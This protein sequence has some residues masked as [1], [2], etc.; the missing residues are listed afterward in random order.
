M[1]H[2][3]SDQALNSENLSICTAQI[4]SS[5]IDSQQS[6]DSVKHCH[7]ND[8]KTSQ[9]KNEK[10]Q[11]ET[12]VPNINVGDIK[13]G[14]SVQN[15]SLFSKQIET[16]EHGNHI[17]QDSDNH[18]S[19]PSK[20][21]DSTP[22]KDS[23]TCE[24]DQDSQATGRPSEFLDKTA[25][26]SVFDTTPGS[27]NSGITKPS[28]PNID[29]NEDNNSDIKMISETCLSPEK[30]SGTSEDACVGPGSPSIEERLEQSLNL[31]DRVKKRLN[32]A[33]DTEKEKEG[34]DDNES[35]IYSTNSK[36]N[37]VEAKSK[38][39]ET[40]EDDFQVG[41]TFAF[42]KEEQNVESKGTNKE[43]VRS[44][45]TL[46]LLTSSDN[47]AVRE[48]ESDNSNGVGKE[49]R[50]PSSQF[51]L[52]DGYLPGVALID[53]D[54][55]V[56]SSHEPLPGAPNIPMRSTPNFSI[57][58]LLG[59]SNDETM[60]IRNTGNVLIDGNVTGTSS[61]EPLPGAPSIPMQSTPNLS[62]PELPEGSNDGKIATEKVAEAAVTDDNVTRA[63]VEISPGRVADSDLNIWIRIIRNP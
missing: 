4:E 11:G 52:T 61:H 14:I 53:G 26:Q 21:L 33:I 25:N 18:G 7:D 24:D 41:N 48:N 49:E 30:D 42:K 19:L 1:V 57:P 58:E 37:A 15:S 51:T 32:A 35:T 39:N 27:Q 36:E 62:I 10:S 43:I 63:R 54:V 28:I 60:E 38:N 23:D 56:A 44:F 34:N 3:N 40:R 9:S 31:L 12:K 47:S 45:N 29:K 16:N 13:D 59:G 22:G 55:T 8:A 17:T 5:E 2:G 50:H 46:E 6:T 20:G